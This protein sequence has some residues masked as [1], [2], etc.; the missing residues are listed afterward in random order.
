MISPFEIAVG[1]ALM[2]AL[3]FL[4]LHVATAMFITEALI[5]IGFGFFIMRKMRAP[6]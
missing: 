5:A 6:R 3:M 2:L 4:G 1:F